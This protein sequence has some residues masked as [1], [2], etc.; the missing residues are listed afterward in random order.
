MRSWFIA[1]ILVGL[2]ILFIAPKIRQ[3]LNN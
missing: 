3:Y 2:S 1:S